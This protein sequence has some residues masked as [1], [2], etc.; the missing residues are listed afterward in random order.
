[1]KGKF[2]DILKDKLQDYSL[3][4]EPR[5]W[6][7]LQRSL[8]LDAE[9]P[10]RIPLYRYVAA[11]AA[12][13]IL[14]VTGIYLFSIRP[15]EPVVPFAQITTPSATGDPAGQ[16]PPAVAA[17]ET[18]NALEAVL[19]L[20]E[21][22]NR[23]KARAEMLAHAST[24]SAAT[25]PDGTG[26]P[27]QP[28]TDGQG[29]QQQGSVG[30]GN[31]SPASVSG[32]QQGGN[33]AGQAQG[34]TRAGTTGRAAASGNNPLN[35]RNRRTPNSNW[36][37]ALF[38]DGMTG[39]SGQKSSDMN[40]FLSPAN[41]PS[42]L[43][44]SLTSK[45]VVQVEQ[46]TSSGLYRVEASD[47]KHSIPLT[48]G[49]S[50]RKQLIGN[51]G[52]ESG[53][54]YSFLSS[55]SETSSVEV[56]QQLHYLGV[57]LSVTYTPWRNNKFEL[58]GRLGGAADF[59]IAGRH[60]VTYRGENDNVKKTNF[61]AEGVQWSVSANVGITYRL[62]PAMGIYFEPGVSHYFENSNQPDSYW[63]EHPTN[64]NMKIG[65]RTNF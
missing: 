60:K 3:K 53:I 48:F 49:F 2:E 18:D 42:A 47:W 45:G 5:D 33:T 28:G 8:G 6:T 61:N 62:G 57:P 1:M 39:A 7:T 56:K 12:V 25:V 20:K 9:T 32:G 46:G 54:N 41:S 15:E 55:K 31:E 26:I 52:I 4:P 34:N 13:L 65:V 27:V 50:V 63:K 43:A 36:A 29:Q 19:K 11:A 23:S 17:A 44:S 51:W 24:A 35:R 59:N 30:S 37:L 40:S 38:A 21:E 58:Y 22:I 14:A 64:F 10:K 16:V